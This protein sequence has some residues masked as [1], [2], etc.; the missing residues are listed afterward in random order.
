MP[1]GAWCDSTFPDGMCV[2]GPCRPGDCP[3]E[4]VCIRF[5]NGE[6][7]CMLSC[8]SNGDCRDGYDCILDL[9]PDG[10]CSVRD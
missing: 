2:S 10:F 3:E 1:R 8:S 7:Y 4:A 9:G 5:K 6:S